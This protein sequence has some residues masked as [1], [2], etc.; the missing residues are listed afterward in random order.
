MSQM[1]L[2]KSV[3]TFSLWLV[4][5]VAG[6]A[7]LAED[8]ALDV[9][10][11][12]FVDL[13]GKVTKL[14]DYKGKWVIINLWATWCPPCLVEIPDL[15]LFH[16]EHKEKDAIV[17]GVNHEVLAVKKVKTFVESQ[18]ITYPIVRFKGEFNSSETPFGKLRGLPTTYMVNPA[19]TVVAAR[20]GMVDDKM[21]A[22][23]I[24]NYSSPDKK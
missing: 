14:T 23:F 11:V 1:K 6:N 22:K 10:K 17:L 2:Q 7:S 5:L 16:E 20:T 24:E 21:L 3:F 18:M 12:E 15:V 4:M 13:D 8:E 9:S 19:G